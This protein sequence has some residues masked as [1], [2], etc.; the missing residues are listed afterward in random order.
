MKNIDR[1][2]F[3]RNTATASTFAIIAPSLVI[4]AKDVGEQ[5]EKWQR[6][7]KDPAYEMLNGKPDLDRILGLFPRPQGKPAIDPR[8]I[9]ANVKKLK[10]VPEINTGH[11]Y[12]DL[13]I[14]TGLAHIDATF[15]GDHPKYGVGVYSQ[16]EHDGFPPTIIAA[17][18]ALSAWGVNVRASRLF[19]YWLTNF[20]KDDGTFDY[21]G[22]SISE[23]GQLLH[24]ATTLEERA[25]GRGWLNEGLPKLNLIAEY[26]LR[27]ISSAS[28]ENGLISGVPEADTR[29]QVDIYFHNNGWIVKGLERWINLCEKTRYAPSTSVGIIMKAAQKLKA[30]TLTAIRKTWPDDP[31]DWWLPVQLGELVRPRYVTETREASYTNYR[32]WLELLSSGILPSDLA[33]RLVNARLN[34]GGQFCGATRFMD[35][36]DDWPLTEYLYGLWT[37]GRKDD[38]LL[39][40]YGHI[41]YSQCEGHLT[42]YE[43]MSFPGDPQG[44][45]RADYCLPCQLVAARA[46]RLINKS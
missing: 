22:P 30:D 14:K 15:Q 33:N 34:G 3:I 23:Y 13:S 12:L 39:S 37:L 4:P 43:Q 18:D 8:V 10:T 17:V 28:K 32:Y 42:A 6:M 7:M 46:G 25:G 11:P 16:V 2:S 5:V 9:Q 20:V 1:R 40:L 24:T 21:Y 41:A 36:L 38:F 45:R 19:N 35:W 27:L 44:S 26:L 31:C 29:D